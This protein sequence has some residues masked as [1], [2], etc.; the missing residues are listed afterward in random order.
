LFDDLF[1]SGSAVQTVSGG[2]LF[3][4]LE[5]LKS[6]HFL[7]VPEAVLSRNY[8]GVTGCGFVQENGLIQ[9]QPSKVDHGHDDWPEAGVVQA[10]TQAAGVT[11]ACW[12]TI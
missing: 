5:L 10:R 1:E 6:P 12:E 8:F 7:V 3:P 2:V 9:A 4:E 11:M